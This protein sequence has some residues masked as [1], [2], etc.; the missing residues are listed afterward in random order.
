M[1]HFELIPFILQIILIIP[2]L[3]THNHVSARIV[4]PKGAIPAIDST[5]SRLCSLLVPWINGTSSPLNLLKGQVISIAVNSD[6]SPYLMTFDE[7]TKQPNGGV[8]FALHKEIARRGGWGGIKYVL[9]PAMSSFP[10]TTAYLLAILPYVDFYGGGPRYAS[11]ARRSLGIGFTSKVDDNSMTLVGLQN[12]QAKPYKLWGFLE[13]LADFVWLT[14]VAVCIV[15]A[16]FHYLFEWIERRVIVPGGGGG[17][18][19][20]AGTVSGEGNVAGSKS[21]A[22]VDGEEYELTVGNALYQAF[23]DLA[24][25]DSSMQPSA[26]STR[27]LRIGYIAFLYVIIASYTAAL[28]GS[29]ITSASFSTSVTTITDASAKGQLLCVEASNAE[30]LSVLSSAYPGVQINKVD[31]SAGVGVLQAV[32]AGRCIGGLVARWEWDALR[33]AALV[34]PQ[35]QLF[36]ASG[37]IRSFS[38]AWA[39]DNDYGPGSCTTLVG[40]AVT[41]T[42]TDMKADGTFD[43]ILATAK[44]AMAYT[45]TT[46]ADTADAAVAAAGSNTSGLGLTD[47]GGIFVV[48]AIFYGLALVAVVV[49]TVVYGRRYGWGSHQALKGGQGGSGMGE[50]GDEKEEPGGG[51]AGTDRRI[52]FGTWS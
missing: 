42:L 20:D 41:S 15:Y 37:G 36:R 46:C 49:K 19:V 2:F 29:L 13:P 34:N 31:S 32:T 26:W 51:G 43:T 21:F 3:S 24:L 40:L 38:G 28:A 6:T 50:G 22:R 5:K 4:V 48:Y 8:M 11:A 47:L 45:Q 33:S 23:A 39:F 18:N 7:Q 25:A 10:S 35:C 27:L 44:A 12:N 1:G 17:S 52:V 16:L 30:F 14:V 9:T